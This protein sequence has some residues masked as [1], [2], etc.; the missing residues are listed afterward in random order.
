MRIDNV[1]SNNFIFECLKTGILGSKILRYETLASGPKGN[2]VLLWKGPI[3]KK[4]S[5]PLQSILE[6]GC[7][8]YEIVTMIITHNKWIEIYQDL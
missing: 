8:N 6:F 7:K 3:D 2:F 5:I 1:K 4:Y